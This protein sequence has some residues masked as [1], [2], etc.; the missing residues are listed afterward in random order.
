MYCEPGTSAAL[1]D[2]WTPGAAPD[3]DTYLAYARTLDAAYAERLST[4]GDTDEG[5][6]EIMAFI[7]D[8]LDW[9]RAQGGPWFCYLSLQEPF[10]VGHA[11]PA[12]LQYADPPVLDCNDRRACGMAAVEALGDVDKRWRAGPAI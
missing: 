11:P 3:R 12:E 2:G 5:R 7:Q 6:A 9:I 8:R 4:L 1:A 10:N